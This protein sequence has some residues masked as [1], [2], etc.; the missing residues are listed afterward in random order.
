M[1]LTSEQDTL[2]K[3]TPVIARTLRRADL[4]RVIIPEPSSLNSKFLSWGVVGLLWYINHSER[5][6]RNEGIPYV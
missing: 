6:Y 2:N 4:K 1:K 5:C 3:L